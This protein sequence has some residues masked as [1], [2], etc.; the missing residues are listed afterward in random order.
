[1]SRDTTQKRMKGFEPSTFAMAIREIRPEA[2]NLVR[3]AA[4]SMA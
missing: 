2:R 1:M 3:F 4:L